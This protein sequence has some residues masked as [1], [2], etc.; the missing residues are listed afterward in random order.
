MKPLETSRGPLWLVPSAVALWVMSCSSGAEQDRGL[1][2][3]TAGTGGTDAGAEAAAGGGTPT[4]NGLLGD[5]GLSSDAA[6]A[7]MEPDACAARTIE[8]EVVEITMIQPLVLYIMLDQ[9]GSMGGDKWDSA[10]SA[11]Q[12]FSQDGLSESLSVALQYFPLDDQLECDL[13]AYSTPDVGPVAVPDTSMQVM[14]SLDAHGPGGGT[15][16]GIALDGATRFCAAHKAGTPGDECVAVIVTDGKPDDDCGYTGNGAILDVARNAVANDGTRTFAVGFDGAD[17]DLM[18]QIAREGDTDCDP[19]GTPND[20]CDVTAGGDA[21][22]QALRQIRETVSTTVTTEL[23]CEWGLPDAGGPVD[24][25]RVNVSLSDGTTDVSLGRVDSAA[26]CP[27]FD[28][29]WYYDDPAAPTRVLACPDT[30]DRV[31]S[32]TNARVDILLDCAVVLAVP[33]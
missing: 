33:K 17:F 5:S 21:F 6:P 25:D 7:P 11:I 22:L 20:A 9:S 14:A 30:C 27:R 26:D 19:A 29:G 18:N 10:V 3:A 15:P 24:P 31:R 8:A 16:I 28:S 32:T 13:N 23:E 1:F 2:P 12:Q 4:G